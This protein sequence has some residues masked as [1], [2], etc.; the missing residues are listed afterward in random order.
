MDR[1]YKRGVPERAG[2]IHWGG[3]EN[4]DEAQGGRGDAFFDQ[5]HCQLDIET[6]K[7]GEHPSWKQVIQFQ[8]F[9]SCLD[10]QF[11]F[12]LSSACL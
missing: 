1:S 9:L 10:A 3:G 12:F 5:Q 6:N 7:T 2:S 8:Q 4:W 11:M